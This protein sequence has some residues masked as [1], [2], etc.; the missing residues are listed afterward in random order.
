VST[1]TQEE[2]EMTNIDKARALIQALRDA[3]TSE[4]WSGDATETFIVGYLS[5]MLA[6]AMD[7]SEKVVDAV[8]GHTEMAVARIK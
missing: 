7:D 1:A 5:G 4:G 2:P 6:D 8:V 3:K